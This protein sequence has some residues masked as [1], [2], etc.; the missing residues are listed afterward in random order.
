MPTAPAITHAL[1]FDIE[2]WFHMAE[3]DA[4]KDPA[5]WT[6]FP[7]LVVERT[8]LI[9]RI[10]EE[11]KTKATFFILGWVADR[12][13]GVVRD[14]DAAGHEIASHG[15]WHQLVYTQTPEVFRDD[16][17]RSRDAI[18]AHTGQPIAGYR[19]PSFSIT[20]GTEWAFDEIVSAGFS[21]DASLF[22][23]ARGQGGYPCPQGSHVVE[24]PGARTLRELPM[25]VASIGLGPLRKRMCYSGGGY[26][27][28]LPL[29]MIEQGIEAESRAGR[30]TVVYLHPRDFAPDCPRVPMPI[31]RKFR[32]YVGLHT[33]ERKLRALLARHRWG[34]CSHVLGVALAPPSGRADTV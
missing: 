2:D 21:Y 28:L 19:A 12:Y 20:P 26:M 14:I 13:P 30:P 8:A 11:H 29:S 22:P 34:T 24:R 33:T 23:A 16:L 4:V 31:S 1:S 3:I 27:R 32:S 5:S 9:L 10:L 17:R 25:S 18:G 7:S 15:Y 6:D